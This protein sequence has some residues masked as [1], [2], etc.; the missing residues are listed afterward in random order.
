MYN[1][2]QSVL[3][4]YTV[5]TPQQ[6][7]T[8]SNDVASLVPDDRRSSLGGHPDL[9]KSGDELSSRTYRLVGSDVLISDEMHMHM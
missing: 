5:V 8:P 9:W 1:A 2:S 3:E 6:P 7:G 4:R